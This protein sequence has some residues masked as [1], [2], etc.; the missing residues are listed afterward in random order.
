MKLVAIDFETANQK[1]ES[2]CSIGVSVFEDGIEIEHFYTLIK[3]LKEHGDFDWRNIQIHG[4]N[5]EDVKDAEGF[6]KVY[7]FLSKYFFDAYFVAHNADFDMKVFK[8]CCQA[9]RLPIP[10][11]QYFCSVRL[12]R[13]FFPYLEN[14]KLNTCANYLDIELNHHNALSDAEAC[15]LIVINCMV[16]INVFDLDEFLIQSNT[17]LRRLHG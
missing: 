1:P 17:V 6:L 15:A 4:I 2:A 16:L 9:N 13:R 7:K 11:M 5:P 14:H 8:S 10:N 3:P 12:A